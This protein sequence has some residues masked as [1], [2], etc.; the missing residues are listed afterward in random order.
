MQENTKETEIS[1][2]EKENPMQSG[3]HQTTRKV[4]SGKGPHRDV[5]V[6]E[7]RSSSSALWVFVILPYIEVE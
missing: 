1:H 5:C 7:L 4:D 3:A 2:S 6:E